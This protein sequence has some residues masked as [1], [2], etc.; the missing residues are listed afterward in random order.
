MSDIGLFLTSDCVDLQI[1]EEAIQFDE[2]LETA[3]LI[4]LFSDRRITVEKLPD[5]ETDRRGW[6]ADTISEIEND[7]IGSEL[8]LYD[9][10]KITTQTLVGLSQACEDALNWLVEDGVA[11]NIEV[12]SLVNVSDPY[13]VD[14]SILIYRPKTTEPSRF[15]LVWDGQRLKRS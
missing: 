1:E 11:D 4:S 8:W 7:K 13:R 3:V 14:I 9:R 2:G 12:E 6:W 15:D 5:L 10:E